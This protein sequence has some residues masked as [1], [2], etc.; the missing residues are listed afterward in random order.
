MKRGGPNHP[1]T[2]ALAEALGIRRAHAVGI[3]EML[4]HFAAQY[5]PEG[6]IGRY[7]DKRIAAAVDW[8]ASVSRL[9]DS[10]AATG[11]IDTHPGVGWVVHGWSEHADKAVR[12]RM[13]RLGKT[14]IQ[15]N[16]KDGVKVMPKRSLDCID[17]GALPEPEPEPEP[18][19][20]FNGSKSSSNLKKTNAFKSKKLDDEKLKVKPRA[21]FHTPDE[22]LRAIYTEKTGLAITKEL[23][24]RIWE[25][26]ELRA[27]P[28]TQF[29]T[30]LRPHSENAWKNPAG[31][32]TAF[33]RR[34]GQVAAT[35][36]VVGESLPEPERNA[37]GRCG[38]CNGTGKID[39]E[40]CTC[41]LGHDFKALELRALGKKQIEV[42]QTQA[43]AKEAKA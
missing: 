21:E 27:I 2:Y 9:I 6:D 38:A 34:I 22:E 8:G 7:S 1:K 36:V 42:E 18:P 16:H 28:K 19:K 35:R 30:E 4:F 23:E 11:W 14:L 25:T 24:R 32:L 26:V 39:S 41:A 20:P 13:S 5:A 10:L 43:H 37:W 40:W 31:F 29:I 17:M 12:L 33:A 3:L 15:S